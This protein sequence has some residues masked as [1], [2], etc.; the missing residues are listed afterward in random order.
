VIDI[1]Q[2]KFHVIPQQGEVQVIPDPDKNGRDEY[3]NKLVIPETGESDGGMYIC[4]VKN[5]VGYKFK[6]AYLTV[7]PSKIFF[8]GKVLKFMIGTLHCLQKERKTLIHTKWLFK[9]NTSK[10]IIANSFGNSFDSHFVPGQFS[11][12]SQK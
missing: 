10:S 5:P 12:G 6:N 7:V 4:F 11:M 8:I 1:G 9:C 2:E 3:V